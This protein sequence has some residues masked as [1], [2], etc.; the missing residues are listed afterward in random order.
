M[1]ARGRFVRRIVARSLVGGR[2]CARSGS[3]LVWLSVAPVVFGVASAGLFRLGIL[4]GRVRLIAWRGFAGWF[5]LGIRSVAL[6]TGALFLGPRLPGAGRFVGRGLLVS[7]FL[8]LAFARL[9]CAI[10]AGLGGLIFRSF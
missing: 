10:C 1:L 3:L 9:A 2:F 6:L 4:L 8:E 7:F 5:R